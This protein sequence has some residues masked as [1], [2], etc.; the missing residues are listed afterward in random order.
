MVVPD[1]VSAGL[2]ESIIGEFNN[3]SEWL[4]CAIGD[5]RVDTTVRN[6]ETII[7]S[8]PHVVA[9]NPPIRKEIDAA[10]YSCA[11]KAISEYNKKFSFAQVEEDSGY[12]LLRYG[13]GQFY[14]EH[15]DSCKARPREVSCSFS[16][17]D[18]YDGG[19]WKFFGGRH[20]I[21]VPKGGAILFPSNFMYPHQIA[22]VTRGVRYSVITWFI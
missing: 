5:G 7:L 3:D 1:L 11:A 16:L 15:V 17:N 21:K 19:E 12:E 4:T 13:V 22:P 9:V 18:D 10:L 14:T 2:C 8:Y 6:V 20:V